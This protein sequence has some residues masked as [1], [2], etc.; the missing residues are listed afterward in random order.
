MREQ[1]VGRLERKRSAAQ[2]AA[3]TIE[4]LED[5][6]DFGVMATKIIAAIGGDGDVFW[7]LDERPRHYFD[8]TKNGHS[9]L[10]SVRNSPTW[11]PALYES[12]R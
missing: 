5:T 4:N 7:V 12:F 6:D 2:A 8:A 10:R 9:R 11:G 1:P 3:M